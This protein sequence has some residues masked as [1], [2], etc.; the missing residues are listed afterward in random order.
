VQGRNVVADLHG[1]DG[2][3]RLIQLDVRDRSDGL[4]AHAHLVARHELAGVLEDR[5]DLVLLRA[6]EHREGHEGYGSDQRRQ[7]ENSRHG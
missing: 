1:H 5:L 2:V 3:G 6:P 4:A 7:R